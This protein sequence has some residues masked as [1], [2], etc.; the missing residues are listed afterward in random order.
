M[1]VV[2]EGGDGEVRFLSA[3]T[4]GSRFLRA[5]AAAFRAFF[6]GSLAVLLYFSS[7]DRSMMHSP[8]TSMRPVKGMERGRE[9]MVLSW[10]RM[11]SPVTPLPRVAPWTSR[12]FS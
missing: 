1:A 3:V 2:D 8:W 7:T 4:W 6:K 12:P 11:A 5:P 9:R 10:G